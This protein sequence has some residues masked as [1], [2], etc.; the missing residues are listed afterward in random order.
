LDVQGTVDM[1]LRSFAVLCSRSEELV[2]AWMKFLTKR[3]T[4]ASETS[5]RTTCKKNCQKEPRLSGSMSGQATRVTCPCRH[6][7]AGRSLDG[8][9]RRPPLPLVGPAAWANAGMLAWHGR[10]PAMAHAA[11]VTPA[12]RL[13]LW[14]Q[15]PP[16]KMVVDDDGRQPTCR[17]WGWRQGLAGFSPARDTCRPARCAIRDVVLFNNFF[18]GGL[19]DISLASGPFR[20]KFE[21]MRMRMRICVHVYVITLHA[22]TATY[23]CTSKLSFTVSISHTRS[24]MPCAVRSS[25]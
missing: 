11:S 21:R 24:C 14:R 22:Y 6:P 19:F 1:Q 12:C 7:S 23:A 10:V 2:P 8:R 4:C 5:K 16:L 17:R 9:R 18:L 25:R 13:W 3:I 20:Q 15:G